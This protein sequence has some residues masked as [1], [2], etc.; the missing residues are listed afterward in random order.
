MRGLPKSGTNPRGL[1]P[2]PGGKTHH[3]GSQWGVPA[4]GAR[5][6]PQNLLPARLRRWEGQEVARKMKAG[7]RGMKR[8]KLRPEKAVGARGVPA[9]WAALPTRCLRTGPARPSIGEPASGCCHALESGPQVLF[10][11]ELEE[12]G[13]MKTSRARSLCIPTERARQ[14]RFTM[15][16]LHQTGLSRKTSGKKGS[17]SP[18]L[19]GRQP[20]FAPVGRL[21]SLPSLVAGCTPALPQIRRSASAWPEST[22]ASHG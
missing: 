17:V 13:S 5:R 2:D 19:A 7:V 9:D 3:P 21:D 12:T 16:D 10:L 20:L 11:R 22:E 8:E 15:H 6:P 14:A 18:Y 1:A 4:G